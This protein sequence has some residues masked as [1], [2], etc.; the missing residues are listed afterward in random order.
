MIAS[1]KQAQF[2]FFYF[3]QIVLFVCQPVCTTTKDVTLP[4]FTWVHLDA[5]FCKRGGKV[6]WLTKKLVMDF[7]VLRDDDALHILNPIS[8]VFTSSMAF[9][10][11]VVNVLLE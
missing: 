11:Y 3:D 10:R 6:R 5:P 1:L 9:A 4:D 8:P 2:G 7:V